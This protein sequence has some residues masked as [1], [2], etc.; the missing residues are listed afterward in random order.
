MV[1]LV[2]GTKFN[3]VNSGTDAIN[4]LHQ[5]EN[6]SFAQSVAESYKYLMLHS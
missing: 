6:F 5:M 1:L 2:I 4:A 3:V